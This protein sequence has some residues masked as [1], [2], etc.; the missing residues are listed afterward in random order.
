[1]HE[2]GHFVT[3]KRSG[4]KITQAFLFFGPTLWSFQ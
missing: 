1:L 3:A 4:I 2:F